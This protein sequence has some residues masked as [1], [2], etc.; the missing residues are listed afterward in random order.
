MWTEHLQKLTQGNYE[1][2][3]WNKVQ[4]LSN[5]E[6]GNF[7]DKQTKHKAAVKGNL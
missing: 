1:G 4:N 6:Q 7:I 5:K 3:D 2:P